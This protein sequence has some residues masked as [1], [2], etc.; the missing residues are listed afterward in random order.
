MLDILAKE[1]NKL[2]FIEG[3]REI[4]VKKEIY[5]CLF[6]ESTE[7]RV[8]SSDSSGFSAVIE[9]LKAGQLVNGEA[10][11]AIS[12]SIVHINAV[13]S[14]AQVSKDESV[15]FPNEVKLHNS[16]ETINCHDKNANQA[17]VCES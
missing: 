5:E 9:D 1:Y 14:K 7:V 13:L 15:E 3:K 10:I 8:H 16:A 6:G 11:Q 4:Q 17:H 12:Q 2:L